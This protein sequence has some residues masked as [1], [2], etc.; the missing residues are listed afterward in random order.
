MSSNYLPV[1]LQILGKFELRPSKIERQL[2][3]S[4]VKAR[5][6]ISECKTFDL[7]LR[8]YTTIYQ[9]LIDTKSLFSNTFSKNLH[10]IDPRA[11]NFFLLGFKEVVFVH[12]SSKDFP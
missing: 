6:F 5:I 9:K 1:I 2:T 10:G 11:F 12:A 8:L 7:E 3:I 4:T